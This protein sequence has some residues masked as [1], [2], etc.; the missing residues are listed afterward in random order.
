MLLPKETAKKILEEREK[1]AE[2]MKQAGTDAVIGGVG[3]AALGLLLTGG[4]PYG[5]LVG[6]YVGSQ[7][8]IVVGRMVRD[9]LDKMNQLQKEAQEIENYKSPFEQGLHDAAM[10]EVLKRREAGTYG[11]AGTD[12]RGFFKIISDNIKSNFKRRLDSVVFSLQSGING[13]VDYFTGP[14]VTVLGTTTRPGLEEGILGTF[15]RLR[16]GFIKEFNDAKKT[17]Q[18]GIDLLWNFFDPQEEYV[19][20]P[21]ELQGPQQKEDLMKRIGKF[22]FKYKQNLMSN[23]ND[24]RAA[25]LNGIEFAWNYLKGINVEGLRDTPFL[26]EGDEQRRPKEVLMTRLGKTFFSL[27]Q[28]FLANVRDAKA[29]IMEGIEFAWN[30]LKGIRVKE[31]GEEQKKPKKVLMARIS[32]GL[33]EAKESFLSAFKDAK[34]D[35]LSG[36]EFVWNYLKEINVE[37]GPRDTPFLGEGDEQ[38]RPKEVLMRRIHSGMDRAYYT[39]K[40]EFR[41]AKQAIQ[42]AIDDIWFY[43]TADPADAE[44]PD[45]RIIRTDTKKTT[46]KGQVQKVTD[47][48]NDLKERFKNMA[49]SAKDYLWNKI[50]GVWAFFT[51]GSGEGTS[52]AT[53]AESPSSA[54]DNAHKLLVESNKELVQLKGLIKEQDE[55]VQAVAQLQ[56]P[57]KLAQTRD[58]LV[59]KYESVTS[60]IKRLMDDPISSFTEV[61]NKPLRNVENVRDQLVNR[62]EI[63]TDVVGGMVDEPISHFKSLSDKVFSTTQATRV[64]GEK[65]SKDYELANKETSGIFA[66]TKN[67]LQGLVSDAQAFITGDTTYTRRTAS[68][69]S[70]K[71][72]G[73]LFRDQQ[74]VSMR[75][76][77]GQNKNMRISKPITK[78]EQKEFAK[79]LAEEIGEKVAEE[80]AKPSRGR[81]TP[82]AGTVR[83]VQS[84]TNIN[85]FGRGRASGQPPMFAEDAPGLLMVNSGFN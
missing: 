36:I 61:K 20:Q 57:G 32:E 17:L 10:E 31:K 67:F 48:V 73:S 47:S 1:A 28:N 49:K 25:I 9:H 39:L 52:E 63:V 80:L 83:P 59:G 54:M 75:P 84:R 82:Q 33:R 72:L 51:G 64:L 70:R 35:L 58:F 45:P 65:L 62:Y 8:G 77:A 66:S 46:F 3:G 78:N 14:E 34:S 69:P 6:G 50:K 74:Q 38:R 19:L 23:I 13:L 56:T 2:K 22:F 41:E 4:N 71:A 29:R 5:A 27:K 40:A 18:A 16:A 55:I 12:T 53:T 44:D 11:K 81:L 21:E 26:G 68:P 7:A 76:A 60:S 30:Y 79:V 85:N 24:A 43:F 37:E 15:K 42:N